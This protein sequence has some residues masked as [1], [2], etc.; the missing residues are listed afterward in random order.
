MKPFAGIPGPNREIA[1]KQSLLMPFVLGAIDLE[2]VPDDSVLLSPAAPS[3][4][5]CAGTMCCD[6]CPLCRPKWCTFGCIRLPGSI[7]AGAA[8]TSVSA[9]P[10]ALDR[11]SDAEAT[12]MCQLFCRPSVLH[13][14]LVHV[15]VCMSLILS[16]LETFPLCS[17][18]HEAL[19][20]HLRRRADLNK[21]KVLT[22]YCS[23]LPMG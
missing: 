18:R 9:L 8:P 12:F 3:S 22:Y 1:C 16:M 14:G 5:S 21:R 4:A 20:E 19:W 11:Y 7:C 23:S 2:A 6:L 15:F 17:C 13:T 10:T